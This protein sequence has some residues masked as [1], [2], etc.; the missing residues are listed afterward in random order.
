MAQSMSNAVQDD[1]VAVTIAVEEERRALADRVT[2]L[3]AGGHDVP[4]P[5]QLVMRN[6]AAMAGLLGNPPTLVDAQ[7][8]FLDARTLSTNHEPNEA[9]E[10]HERLPC[11]S[12]MTVYFSSEL[13]KAPCGHIYC[14][15]CATQL[16]QASF[17][18]D[19]LFPP[20]CCRFVFPVSAVRQF[21]GLDIANRYDEKSIERSDPYRTYCSNP[22]CAQYIFPAQVNLY[23]GTCNTCAQKTCTLC[24]RPEHPQ[25]PCAGEDTEVLDLAEREGWRRCPGCRN[26]VELKDG[27]NHI[28]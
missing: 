24:K 12:C 27:C 7:G 5:E 13:M 15:V 26:L 18:D 16:I 6:N 20:R 21:V 23:I 25:G 19:S 9:F 1:G 4:H 8:S 17:V 3:R 14:R 22:Q 10:N 2:A 11:A 28:T